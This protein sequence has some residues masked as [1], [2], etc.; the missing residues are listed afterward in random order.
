MGIT[1]PRPFDY[2]KSVNTRVAQAGAGAAA[3]EPLA[4]ERPR[5]DLASWLKDC[6]DES[7]MAGAGT[8]LR[9]FTVADSPALVKL[10]SFARLAQ[11]CGPSQHDHFSVLLHR[12]PGRIEL[13]IRGAHDGA[14]VLAQ[15]PPDA[16]EA[17]LL[18]SVERVLRHD[19]TP[20]GAG[21]ASRF[22]TATLTDAQCRVM[23]ALADPRVGEALYQAVGGAGAV[24]GA[25]AAELTTQARVAGASAPR[26]E[27]RALPNHYLMVTV[28]GGGRAVTFSAWEDELADK[29]QDF[30][31]LM[32][33]LRAQGQILDLQMQEA[34]RIRSQASEDERR[35]QEEQSLTEQELERDRLARE[36][37][38]LE[39]AAANV[40][41]VERML[42]GLIGASAITAIRQSD[43]AD[44]IDAARNDNVSATFLVA[45]DGTLRCVQT[46]GAARR[47]VSTPPARSGSDAGDWTADGRWADPVEK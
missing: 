3:P 43:V 10:S 45:P 31:E 40:R 47:G 2:G 27:P 28:R 13:T 19:I 25:A 46:V 39:I 41:Q 12:P 7:A 34:E 15:L 6:V 4:S 9:N 20:Q 11:L 18:A 23:K 44:G 5:E 8:A 29:Q 30:E 35:L 1:V 17:R 24:P 42:D 16:N 14:P 37:Q 21:L 36:Q 32:R 38:L 33:D 22:S 26:V